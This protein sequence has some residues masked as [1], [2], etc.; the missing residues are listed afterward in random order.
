MALNLSAIAETQCSF[1]PLEKNEKNLSTSYIKEK[2]NLE[3]SE[4]NVLLSAQTKFAILF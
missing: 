4:L 3:A 1:L 2:K